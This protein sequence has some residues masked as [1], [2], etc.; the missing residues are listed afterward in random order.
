MAKVTIYHKETR[1]KDATAFYTDPEL[2]QYAPAGWYVHNGQRR[3][4]NNTSS[5]K[6]LYA[7]NRCP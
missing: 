2:T 5:T 6:Y 3:Y 4:F 7:Q 1:F